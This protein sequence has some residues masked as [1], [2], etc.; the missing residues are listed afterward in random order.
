MRV[1]PNQPDAMGSDALLWRGIQVEE[2]SRRRTGAP[3]VKASNFDKRMRYIRRIEA[4]ALRL[5][6]K[7]KV[8]PDPDK[9]H[10][11]AEAAVKLCQTA[12]KLREQVKDNLP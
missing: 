5:T 10:V 11:L 8:E 9:R 4:T 6:D 2:V 1:P 3:M 12:R 7:A